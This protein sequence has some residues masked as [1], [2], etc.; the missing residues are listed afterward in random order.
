MN[1]KKVL[2]KKICAETL[3]QA[4]PF[5]LARLIRGECRSESALNRLYARIDKQKQSER[6]RANMF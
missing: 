4:L 3:A 2:I 5:S 6:A 1:N